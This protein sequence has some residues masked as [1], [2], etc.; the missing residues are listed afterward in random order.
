MAEHGWVAW[1]LG[2]IL[3]LVCSVAL[4]FGIQRGRNIRSAADSSASRSLT[5]VQSVLSAIVSVATLGAA[6]YFLIQGPRLMA[7]VAA[8]LGAGILF[9]Q[10]RASDLR[11]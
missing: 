2:V 5:T 1:T 3:A 6:G 8:C 4:V 9:F 11:R 10:R 7:L